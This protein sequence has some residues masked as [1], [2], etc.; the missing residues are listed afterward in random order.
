[1]KCGNGTPTA[2]CFDCG[3]I[4]DVCFKPPSKGPEFEKHDP[5]TRRLPQE[6]Y[7]AAL[8]RDH[9]APY[10]PNIYACALLRQWSQLDA[11]IV[12]LKAHMESVEPRPHKDQEHA[13]A[14]RAKATEMDQWRR[15]HMGTKPAAGR[16]NMTGPEQ[17]N[18]PPNFSDI[19]RV[20][21]KSIHLVAVGQL[22][23][24]A[25]TGDVV[26]GTCEGI[27]HRLDS[28]AIIGC[29]APQCPFNPIKR[30]MLQ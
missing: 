23:T 7:W 8:A 27:V 29:G 18:D 12:N 11:I 25:D 17:N 6:P 22:P 1:M 10:L 9:I 26:C 20:A 16:V 19:L 24:P 21:G 2:P 5:L 13:W 3:S 4:N 28:G 15:D 14:S 30:P